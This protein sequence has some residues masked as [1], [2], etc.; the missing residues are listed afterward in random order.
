MLMTGHCRVTLVVCLAAGVANREGVRSLVFTAQSSVADAPY[1]TDRIFDFTNAFSLK[2]ISDEQVQ[3]QT[4][5][6]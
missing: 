2:D 6:H 4:P 5:Q 3:R 1:L